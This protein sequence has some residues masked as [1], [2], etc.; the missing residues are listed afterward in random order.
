MSIN[1]QDVLK[2]FWQFDQKKMPIVNV[3]GSFTS[4]MNIKLRQE[5]CE[6]WLNAF[7]GIDTDVW[8]KVIALALKECKSYPDYDKMYELIER[9][10]SYKAE[11]ETAAAAEPV[12]QEEKPKP[13]KQPGYLNNKQRL[14]KMFEL[15]KSGNFNGAAACCGS[16]I[17]E[18]DLEAFAVKYWPDAAQRIVKSSAGELRDI[19]RQD[20]ICDE[21]DGMK[22]CRTN[23]YRTVGYIDKYS[24]CL[25]TR[26]V[27]CRERRKERQEQGC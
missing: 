10:S 8:E 24:G 16:G 1:R 4:T 27:E 20:R 23:G 13:K 9:V 19:I 11:I 21:C 3:N 14:A 2:A 6:E 18:Q 12:R 17:T 26:M 5:L 7:D 22:K 15:A 25:C